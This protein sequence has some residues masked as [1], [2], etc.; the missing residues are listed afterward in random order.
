MAAVFQPNRQIYD[1]ASVLNL[2][3]TK[4]MQ[5]TKSWNTWT[6]PRPSQRPIDPPTWKLSVLQ[7]L[8][9]SFRFQKPGIKFSV[10]QKPGIKFSKIIISHLWEKAAEGW[11]HQISLCNPHFWG[12]GDVEHS[13][14][15]L[16]LIQEFCL[17]LGSFA[18][19]RAVGHKDSINEIVQG[20]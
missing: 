12:E 5:F 16:V 19:Q 4:R 18:G 9:L 20:I 3:L 10:L 2:L 15:A 11:L 6:A 8:E 14:F 7:N 13:G 1:C 17:S